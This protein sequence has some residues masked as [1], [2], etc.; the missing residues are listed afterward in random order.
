MYENITDDDT[1]IAQQLYR[2]LEKEMSTHV[3]K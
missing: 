3:R 1:D 2:S